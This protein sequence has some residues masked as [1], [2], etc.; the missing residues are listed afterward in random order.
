LPRSTHPADL[1]VEAEQEF[2]AFPGFFLYDSLMTNRTFK[3]GESREQAVLSAPPP[4]KFGI[5]AQ[6][7]R[8]AFAKSCQPSRIKIFPFFR[9]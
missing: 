4:L 2:E 1:L 6:P 3:T 9:R 8:A 7:R 5:L